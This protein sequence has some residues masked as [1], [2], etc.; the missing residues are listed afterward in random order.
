ML[1]SY[2]MTMQVTDDIEVEARAIEYV[3]GT[4]YTHIETV[5]ADEDF[6]VMLV[7]RLKDELRALRIRWEQYR[8]IP[9][10]AEALERLKTME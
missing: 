7:K 3:P 8:K 6:S 1:R 9:E 4:G 5:L 10:I 2:T